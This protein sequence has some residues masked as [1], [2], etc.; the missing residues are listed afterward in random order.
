MRGPTQK[1]KKKK[2][3]FKN[4]T[5]TVAPNKIFLVEYAN[6]VLQT[7]KRFYKSVYQTSS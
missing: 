1:K 3:V 2:I 6:S 7:W 4:K 5:E